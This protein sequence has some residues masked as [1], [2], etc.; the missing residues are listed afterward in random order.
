LRCAKG[1]AGPSP[2]NSFTT[3]ADAVPTASG[4]RSNA[5]AG[6]RRRATREAAEAF[7]PM[8]FSIGVAVAMAGDDSHGDVIRP[9]AGNRDEE[10][11]NF[12]RRSC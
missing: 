2:A 8:F 9:T 11:L 7:F 5:R 6:R 4:H 1:V 3:L 10:A 12:F